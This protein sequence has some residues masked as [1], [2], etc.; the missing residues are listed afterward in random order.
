MT[1]GGVGA[2]KKCPSGIARALFAVS[3]VAIATVHTW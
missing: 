2:Y 3:E 1:L